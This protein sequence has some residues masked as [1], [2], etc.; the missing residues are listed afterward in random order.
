VHTQTLGSRQNDTT[1]ADSTPDTRTADSA[2]NQAL[3]LL[4]LNSSVV[5]VL[6]QARATCTA[7]LLRLRSLQVRLPHLDAC[8]SS[9]W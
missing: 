5:V 9:W 7:L 2:V 4:F 3:L 8:S 1:S 6:E